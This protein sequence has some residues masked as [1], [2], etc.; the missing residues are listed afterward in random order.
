MYM[1]GLI[2]IIIVQSEPISF[3][4]PLLSSQGMSRICHARAAVLR[5][6]S[7]SANCAS[8]RL[9]MLFFSFLADVSR[10]DGKVAFALRYLKFAVQH[11]ITLSWENRGLDLGELS[12]DSSGMVTNF[13]ALMEAKHRSLLDA[14]RKQWESMEACGDLASKWPADN[15]SFPFHDV[16]MYLVLVRRRRRLQQKQKWKNTSAELMDNLR[17]GL[18][19]AL[20]NVLDVVIFAN[21]DRHSNLDIPSRVLARQSLPLLLRVFFHKSFGGAIVL[22]AWMTGFQ[23][24]VCLVVMF[25]IGFFACNKMH[26]LTVNVLVSPVSKEF[27]SSRGSAN[28]MSNFQSCGALLRPEAEERDDGEGGENQPAKPA[29]RLHSH[30]VWELVVQ[31]Q[32]EHLSLHRLAKVKRGGSAGSAGAWQNKLLRM[33]HDRAESFFK[34]AR[35]LVVITDG[36]THGGR[37][38]LVS[39][40]HDP[41]LDVAAFA[42]CQTIWA[43]KHAIAGEYQVSE[44]V[45]RLLAR[46]EAERLSSY[47]FIQALSK[48]IHLITGNLDIEC[49]HVPEVY[50]Y[51]ITPMKPGWRRSVVNGYLKIQFSDQSS[52]LI[53]VVAAAERLPILTVVMDQGSVGTAAFAFLRQLGRGFCV[54]AD[55]D[56]YHRLHRDMQLSQEHSQQACLMQTQMALQYWFG[57]NYKPFNSGAFFW[58]KNAALQSFIA[59]VDVDTLPSYEHMSQ[60]F[61]GV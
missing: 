31:A 54:H 51:A 47:K 34:F 19:Q 56:K 23:P 57:I 42:T 44:E 58:E 7:L 1:F 36:S 27:A 21:L 10:T 2:N 60:E 26:F 32:E 43:L 6:G 16:A 14:W 52:E 37:N 17:L 40:V 11:A 30:E 29:K 39:I 46:R 55:F 12:L 24:L 3:S 4:F 18:I 49:F 45:E 15:D 8:T 48:Q 59:E 28:N 33:Y 61:C 20:A 25:M 35:H 5:L 41:Q 13:K 22:A 38:T 53:D 50:F 9:M